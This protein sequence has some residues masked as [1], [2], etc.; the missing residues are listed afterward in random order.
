MNLL[1][2]HKFWPLC[3]SSQQHQGGRDDLG[4]LLEGAMKAKEAMKAI[5]VMKMMM[6]M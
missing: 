2:T 5:M 1:A 4:E 6:M 3:E